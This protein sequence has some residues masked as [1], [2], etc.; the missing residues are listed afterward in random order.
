VIGKAELNVNPWREV[1]RATT[2][3]CSTNLIRVLHVFGRMQR[4]GAEMRTLDLMRQVDRNRFQLEFCTLSGLPGELDVEIEALGG[5][6]HPC[7]LGWG[8]PVAFVRLL[9]SG[10]Y[11]VV[12][13]HVMHSSGFILQC[14]ALAGVPV[15]VAHFRNTCDGASPSFRRK[16]QQR[17]MKQALDKSATRIL[18]VSEGAMTAAW[19]P[20]WRDDSRC[21]VMYNVV[22]IAPYQ[23]APD[24][25]AVR[26]QFGISDDAQLV[27]HV[28]RL[29]PQK[30]HARLLSI[31]AELMKNRVDAHLLIV[32]RGEQQDSE[33]LAEQA[34]QLGIG[35][36]MTIAGERDDVPRLL[37]ASDLM[38]FPSFWEGMPGVVL[39]A[40][41]AG[42]PVVASDLPGVNEIAAHFS[43]VHPISLNEPDAVWAEECHRLL[44]QKGEKTDGRTALARFRG[45]VFSPERNRDSHCSVWEGK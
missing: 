16:I 3:R 33:R 7:R 15:R 23:L 26:G 43:S 19:T 34:Q 9:R 6:I 14:A 44:T 5:T 27:I 41:A 1:D 12:H 18:A 4:G 24:V 21:S 42:T 32:G 17:A 37:Q 8:F 2:D 25:G 28:G 13:S 38:I 20:R 35:Q 30:N 22:D 11:D 36:R 39:E 40:C 31:F 29:H 45:S 10:R